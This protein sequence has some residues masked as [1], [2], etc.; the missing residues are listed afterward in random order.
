MSTTSNRTLTDLTTSPSATWQAW[1]DLGDELLIRMA[2]DTASR[3]IAA[4]YGR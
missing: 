2:I 1:R 3:R 4:G